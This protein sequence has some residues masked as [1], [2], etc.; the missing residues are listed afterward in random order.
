[1]NL[2]LFCAKARMWACGVTL[3]G[4]VAALGQ[5]ADVEVGSNI[6]ESQQL[7]LEQID[8]QLWSALLAKYVNES[9]LVN[10]SAWQQSKR[11][12]DAL[13]LYLNHLSHANGR[14]TK[15]EKLA[16][17]INAYNA[18]T[19]KGILREY[20]TTSIRNHTARFF[21]YN[22]WKNLKLIVAGVAT[23]LDT[24]EHDLLRKMDEPR[25]HFAIVCASLGCPKLLNEAYLPEQVDRQLDDRARAF[26]AESS[27]FR[28]D[29]QRKVFHVSPILKWFGEDFG[30]SEGQRLRSIS[31]WISDTAAAQ[32]ALEGRGSMQYLDYDWALNDWKP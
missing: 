23:S 7:D 32:A 19:I 5:A 13:D 14:G 4:L 21:G 26:F 27:K 22:I 2:R 10:Y 15:E 24:M 28:F 20:P 31:I 16:F 29:P 8:H 12:L 18:L 6:P 30:D 9:G 25:I 3:L 11:D 17:W 1:M